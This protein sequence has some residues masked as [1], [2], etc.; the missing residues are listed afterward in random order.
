[1]AEQEYKMIQTPSDLTWPY[2]SRIGELEAKLEKI[3]EMY[4]GRPE[5][6]RDHLKAR[7]KELVPDYPYADN[8][9]PFTWLWAITSSL[10]G[11]RLAND[12][13]HKEI[14]RLERENL[15]LELKD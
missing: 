11:T 10:E 7:A 8:D 14:D 15:H 13:L 2:E 4:D 9:D 12:D 1:M 6:F 5:G 3:K